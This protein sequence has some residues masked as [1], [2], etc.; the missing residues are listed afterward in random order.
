MH[1]CACKLPSC[2]GGH[3]HPLIGTCH[4]KWL[5]TER[6]SWHRIDLYLHRRGLKFIVSCN[7]EQCLILML[8]FVKFWWLRVKIQGGAG[9]TPKGMVGDQTHFVFESYLVGPSIRPSFIQIGEVAYITNRLLR[10][11][12]PLMDTVLKPRSNLFACVIIFQLSDCQNVL[13]CGPVARNVVFHVI[14]IYTW[15]YENRVTKHFVIFLNSPCLIAC[16]LRCLLMSF[17]FCLF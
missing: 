6:I 1:A 5:E 10:P 15:S 7:Q 9:L 2:L 14:Y 17:F 16:L 11:P 12:G 8:I 13:L 3:W 4:S